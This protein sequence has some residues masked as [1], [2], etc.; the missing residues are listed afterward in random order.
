MIPQLSTSRWLWFVTGGALVSYLAG[1]HAGIVFAATLTAARLFHQV[2]RVR[3]GG[4][5][6]MQIRALA[7]TVMILGSRPGLHVLLYLQLAGI[8]LLVG[9]DYCMAARLL[10]LLPWNR[11]RSL[12]GALLRATFLTPP[13][14]LHLK[15]RC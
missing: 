8:T 1:L 9:F 3:N 2:L 14:S 7:L 6:P 15:G 11:E 5:L 10:S 4:S 13:R 12:T